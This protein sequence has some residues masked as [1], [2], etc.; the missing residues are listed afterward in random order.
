MIKGKKIKVLIISILCILIIT[1]GLSYGY[2][3]IQKNQENNNVAGSKC[4]KLEFSNESE[5]IN[6]SNMYPISDEEGKK[7]VPYS[8]TITNTCDMLAGYTV[9]MEMLEGTTLNSKYLDVM[10]NNEEIK[11]LT[12][13]ESTNTVI[14]GSTE[15]RILAKGTLAYN[16]SVDYTVRFWMDKDVEDIDS[17]NKLFKSKIVISATPS[18]WNPKDA[19]Y[20]TLHDA[21]LA[22]EYQST[23]ADAISKIEAKGEPDLSKPAPAIKWIEKVGKSTFKQVK[24]PTSESIKSVAELID[25]DNSEQYMYICTTK[26]FDFEIGR[27]F[28]SNCSLKDPTTLD[29][30]N[31]NKYYF[32]YE[33]MAY[34]QATS[35]IYV[36]R[37]DS[38]I[39]VYQ[40]SG[41]TKTTATQSIEN[42]TYDVNVYN[43]SCIEL[44]ETNMEID[45]SDKGL[46]QTAD[47]YG[48][49]YY[50][51]GSINN[52]NVYFAGFYW[53][54][55]RINGDGSIRIMYNG[56]K[57][58]ATGLEQSI[59][60]NIYQF[61]KLNDSPTYVGYMYGNHESKIFDEVHAN[62]NDSLIKSTIELWYK[63][64]IDNKKYTDMVSFNVGY[65]GDRTLI[66]GDGISTLQ[67]SSF[68]AYGR[69]I[70]NTAILV[71]PNIKRDL[72]T[73]TKSQIGN[74]ALK[75]PVG[76]ITYDELIFTGMTGKY[77]NR[78]S[79]AYSTQQYW[80]MSPFSF[81]ASNG[82]AYE[83]SLLAEGYVDGDWIAYSYGARPVINLNSN[84]KITGG[85]GTVNN[86]YVVDTN[87]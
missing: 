35:K 61:N 79:W 54:I 44:T 67:Y 63:I 27:Y 59:D 25:L 30:N 18:S 62:N 31:D 43:L 10:V 56:T 4:F 77:L 48:K 65:C 85:I 37:Y 41:A 42:I 53:Q 20:D 70:K 51:R 2:F 13:Y 58:N 50:Y 52:N 60:N 3:F 83:Y 57:K 8:F 7:Q 21:I 22:N 71:C 39:T 87:N 78:F 86:P 66:S 74:K 17:M 40:I 72:Y 64:N 34:Y 49:T 36:Y 47:D 82:S 24:K 55:I 45:N 12:N 76:L 14:T 80:T 16:D 9:N 32:S 38:D 46:Y 81:N 26:N 5:A 11:L 33:T 15:S 19:G 6:L 73:S 84:T 1:I 69:N 68:G 23:P 29:Y 75:Y 28:L